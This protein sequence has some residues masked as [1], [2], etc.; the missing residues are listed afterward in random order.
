MK[1]KNSIIYFVKITDLS[2][3]GPHCKSI[4]RTLGLATVLKAIQVHHYGDK[5]MLLIYAHLRVLFCA[6]I[7]N[8][9]NDTNVSFQGW[10]ID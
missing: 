8:P 9:L 10:I 3:R 2:C 4:M 5:Y 6:S 7:K 1:I